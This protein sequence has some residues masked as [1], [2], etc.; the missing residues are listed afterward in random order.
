MFKHALTQDVAYESLLTT[1]RQTLH[2]MAGQALEQLY[3][4]R[5]ADAYDRLA[6]HYSRTDDAAKAVAYL[7]LV[8]NKAASRHAHTEALAALQDAFT[9]TERLAARERDALR[10]KLV[11]QLVNSLFFLSRFQE[12]LDLL[13]PYQEHLEQN[14]D[15]QSVASYY[16]WLSATYTYL[17]NHH[18]GI[19]NAQRTITMAQR[20]D[21]AVTMGKGY[22]LLSRCSFWLGQLTAARSHCQ[23]AITLLAGSTEQQWLGIAYWFLGWMSGLMGPPQPALEAHAKADAIGVAIGDAGLQALASWGTGWLY[24]SIGEWQ[25]GVDACQRSLALDPPPHSRANGIGFL[26]YTYLEKGE[27]AK[28]ISLLEQAL[29]H[30]QRLH[31]PQLQSWFMSYL[32]EAYLLHGDRAKAY[33]LGCQALTMNTDLGFA[34]GIGLAQRT[35][36][37]IAHTSGNLAEAAR[38]L[39]DARATFDAMEARYDL[40]RTHLDLASLASTQGN[41]DAATSHLST[42]YAWFKTLQMPKW[43][44]RTE[45]LV[46]EYG[47]T[48]TEVALAEMTEG[49]A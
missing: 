12:S 11:L 47:V 25:A 37:R 15:L 39:Q 34:W 41:Q 32:G 49:E 40:A 13:F 8:A 36:G 33:D 35:L 14:Q 46:Q 43:V 18:L 28:A 2:N 4:D 19:P 44:E 27:A 23:Q 22:Y 3:A 16:F 17:G 48:L 1:R 20:C 45:Q 10:F 42:A 30:H 26:G 21:D 38:H 31:R 7:M 5:L 29:Q 9:H 6:Y 24:A